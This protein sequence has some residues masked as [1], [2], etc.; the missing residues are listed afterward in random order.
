MSA[1]GVAYDP[2]LNLERSKWMGRTSS[3][4]G[5]SQGY[6]LVLPSVLFLIES[7]DSLTLGLSPVPDTAAIDLW[8]ADVFL[9]SAIAESELV[10]RMEEPGGLRFAIGLG[11]HHVRVED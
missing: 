1:P 10:V 6:N 5:P 4:L 7:R 3:G 2:V 8:L 11:G 9:L